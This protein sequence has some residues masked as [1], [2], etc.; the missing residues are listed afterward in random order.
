MA[1]MLAGRG[2]P[3]PEVYDV[4]TGRSFPRFLESFEAYCA[5][6]YS[7]RQKDLW[8]AELGRVLKGEA[9][10]VYQACG[11]AD[12]RYRYMK[13]RLEDWY[14]TAKVRDSSSRKA[15]YENARP[16]EGEAFSVFA[17]RLEHLYRKAYPHRSMDGKDLRRKLLKALPV[18]VGDCLE[19]DLTLLKAAHGRAN[20]WN[21]VLALLDAQDEIARRGATR[22]VAASGPWNQPSTQPWSGARPKNM[23]VAT[24]KTQVTPADCPV[25]AELPR[26]RSSSCLRNLQP[27]QST[28][29][30][31]TGVTS[32]G[33]FPETVVA[34]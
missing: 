14:A 32:L 9:L 12:Q 33:T 28:F 6:R 34:A 5:S 3:K 31:V 7:K 26:S 19:R 27:L 1:D 17:T 23:K 2:A 16:N 24:T 29:Q 25:Y 22:E 4:G 15:Q 8:T 21:D 11:G 18:G 10:Q 30:G 13:K 20:N